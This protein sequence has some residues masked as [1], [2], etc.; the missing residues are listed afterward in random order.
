MSAAN[1]TIIL[2]MFC[3]FENAFFCCSLLIKCHI[4]KKK[5]QNRLNNT[6]LWWNFSS[7]LQILWDSLIYFSVSLS[8]EQHTPQ[9][10]KIKVHLFASKNTVPLISALFHSALIFICLSIYLYWVFLVNL[11]CFLCWCC[12]VGLWRASWL[13]ISSGSKVVANA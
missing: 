10:K 9:K 3:N 1:S 12:V 11:L 2:Q 7:F 5:Y 8:L 6:I 13:A 4:M